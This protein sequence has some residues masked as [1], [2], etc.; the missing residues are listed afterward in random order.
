MV[1]LFLLFPEPL[2]ELAD[3][4]LPELCRIRQVKQFR[5]PHDIAD[6]LFCEFQN[7]LV[8]CRV[9]HTVGVARFL[10]FMCGADVV[11]IFVFARGDRLS[12]HRLAAFTAV[13]HAGVLL[14]RLSC[15]ARMRVQ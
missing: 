13:D 7:D 10:H 6:L 5:E 14:Y 1:D 8:Q 3:R 12:H 9:P 15:R 11:H 4:R 2:L